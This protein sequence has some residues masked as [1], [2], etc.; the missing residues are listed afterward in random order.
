MHYSHHDGCGGGPRACYWSY[1]CYCCYWSLFSCPFGLKK[2]HI[3]CC[4]CLYIMNGMVHHMLYIY[5]YSVEKTPAPIA[6]TRAKQFGKHG[7]NV[8]YKALGYV[9]I[10]IYIYYIYILY[11][12]S[13]YSMSHM[14]P[15][16]SYWVSQ[17]WSLEEVIIWRSDPWKKV[18]S[19]PP[20]IVP[21]LSEC[22]W[23]S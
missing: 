10:Y 14:S 20:P 19:C 13:Y 21:P 9:Y 7:Q 16:E 5:I 6:K 23:M 4:T 8:L 18:P 1:W 3:K 22:V 12:E 11:I 15:Y 2:T 17:E